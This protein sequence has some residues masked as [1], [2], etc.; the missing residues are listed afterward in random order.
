M[1]FQLFETNHK[2]T[3][4][5]NMMAPMSKVYERQE[6]QHV[7]SEDNS[8]ME[9]VQVQIPDTPAKKTQRQHSS[10]I[11]MLIAPTNSLEEN[12]E[13]P[14]AEDLSAMDDEVV[15]CSGLMDTILDSIRSLDLNKPVWEEW[16]TEEFAYGYRA[17]LLQTE[18]LAREDE[19]VLTYNLPCS[20]SSSNTENPENHSCGFGSI[21]GSF[22]P[23]V[24]PG[25]AAE[26][27]S[28][29]NLK[30][31]ELVDGKYNIA[32]TNYIGSLK[33]KLHAATLQMPRKRLK[34]PKKKVYRP[35][36]VRNLGRPIPRMEPKT[37]TKKNERMKL[38]TPKMKKNVSL[39]KSSSTINLNHV[40]VPLDLEPIVSEGE[41]S[42]IDKEKHSNDGTRIISEKTVEHC[43]TKCI[44]LGLKFLTKK[45][46]TT[47]GK[48][49]EVKDY[50]R[51]MEPNLL[52]IK[53]KRRMGR[54]RWEVDVWEKIA[55][56]F[57]TNYLKRRRN[58]KRR[59]AP[60]I[61][62]QEVRNI[63][64]TEKLLSPCF[65]TESGGL[66]IEESL[67]GMVSLL[68]SDSFELF[69][70]STD[71]PEDNINV[72]VQKHQLNHGILVCYQENEKHGPH[73]ELGIVAS[74]NGELGM[75]ATTK[76]KGRRQEKLEKLEHG[77]LA[78]PWKL[79]LQNEV[80]EGDKHDP[81]S[82]F[83]DKER[84][85][86]EGRINLFLTRMRIVQGNRKFSQWDGSVMDSIVGVFLTQNVSDH[87]SSSAF[88]SLAAAF[89]YQPSCN[90]EL[91]YA[92]S[93]PSCE[94]SRIVKIEE[95]VEG[96]ISKS[97]CEQSNDQTYCEDI[98]SG[99]HKLVGSNMVFDK[100]SF[101]QEATTTM[102]YE[103]QKSSDCEMVLA[104]QV[105]LQQNFEGQDY[106][107]D[108]PSDKPDCSID[109]ITENSL[110]YFNEEKQ[111][112]KKLKVD[113][114]EINNEVA[115][116][117]G[118]PD[119][120]Y[121]RREIAKERKIRHM[122]DSVDWQAV[123][124]AD[125]DDVAE[126]IKGRGQHRVIAHR[127]KKFLNDVNQDHKE[128]N[129]EWLRWAPDKLA[130]KYL[131]NI[132]GIG[133]KSVEC[134]RLLALKQIAFPVDVNVGR[135]AIRLGW[136]PMQPLP[137][138]VQIHVL[139]EMPV[140]DNIQKYLWPRLMKLTFEELY[141]LHY[142]MIT[143]GKVYCTKRKP[144]CH[145]CPMK[146]ECKYYLSA[147]ASSK[148]AALPKSMKKQ[149]QK[150]TDVVICNNHLSS[151]Y[152]SE[153]AAS[154][155]Y[156]E[157]TTKLEYQIKDCEP[158][159]EEPASPRP[160][161]V[162]PEYVE[163]DIEDLFLDDPFKEFV[164]RRPY[165]NTFRGSDIST[166]VPF[167]TPEEATFIPARRLKEVDRLRT[168]HSVYVI[169]DQGP[170]FKELQLERRHPHD[171]SP[172]L[173]ALCTSDQM[174]KVSQS[175][176]QNRCSCKGS[177]D[178]SCDGEK[179]CFSCNSLSTQAN[180]V[181]GTI[182]IPCRT[183]M[184]GSFPLNGTYFQ[185]NEVF[186]DHESSIRPINV[187]RDLLWDQTRRDVYFGTSTSAILKGLSTYDVAMCFKEGSICVRAFN[188]ETRRPEPLLERF[189]ISTVKTAKKGKKKAEQKED[190]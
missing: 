41:F 71:R 140:M 42:S 23:V 52:K 83:W 94:Q 72:V 4:V 101:T 187:H 121:Y 134:V 43:I 106:Y 164:T 96:G 103:N 151:G 186:A 91:T 163:R 126:A 162:E 136:V 15:D 160:S 22:M 123:R 40:R 177:N 37:P 21:E 173:F 161:L 31:Q 79:Q 20:Q 99:S 17:A 118:K 169:K 7:G 63:F 35:K 62:Q 64:N 165:M 75:V 150:K 81:N 114:R 113:A 33:R 29:Y 157:D 19:E 107:V 167:M 45:K 90:Q 158:I 141:E 61:S 178:S 170:L 44:D 115:M 69:F 122:A 86:F 49:W 56:K 59:A 65:I 70:K 171:N 55:S 135:I 159:I 13:N 89:P 48:K 124:Q 110:S 66:N 120:D 146:N 138:D 6:R 130:R 39:K 137:E 25:Y 57:Q 152:E 76:G 51:I 54:R 185:I 188:R 148:Y 24:Q 147:Y 38:K 128:I 50:S 104:K 88:I 10:G 109:I 142:Q 156:L 174:E 16:E 168:K 30:N 127:I 154:Q 172:Y 11:S 179:T 95:L 14:I 175:P 34:R 102:K 132:E 182:L 116:V 82:E 131:T 181:Q 111:R 87:L 28:Q 26:S 180:T 2:S 58:K 85:F 153:N 144:N 183:A 190:D 5:Q 18:D 12:K 184:R 1:A 80:K 98:N 97:S 67:T 133:L 78:H 68:E 189:H 166:L 73:V 74:A 176:D 92:N 53:K 125:V 60:E 145:S 100:E 93:E 139:E 36:V 105:E 129:L 27:M 32:D 77:E 117:N 149:G 9:R 155:S 112:G 3:V 84:Q 47:M 108:M 119:W 143:F 8:V 46:R